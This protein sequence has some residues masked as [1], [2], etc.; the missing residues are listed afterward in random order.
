MGINLDHTRFAQACQAAALAEKA[1]GGIGT[2]GE[3]TLHRVLK[4][5]FE[6]DEELHEARIGGYVADIARPDG[7]IEI[8]TGSFGRLRGKLECFLPLGPVTVA[9]PVAAIK[10][11]R[12]IDM[13]T[14]ELSEP[15]KSPK[16]G[17]LHE[18]LPELG[19]IREYL[20]HPNFRLCVLLLELEELRYLNGW[21]NGG[22]RG[23]HRCDRLP[24]ALVDEQYFTTP[25]DYRRLLPAGLPCPFRSTDLRAKTR[26]GGF[27]NSLALNA[28]KAAGA[29]KIVGKKGNAFLYE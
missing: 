13:Q 6:P 12:W 23:S 20:L 18:V 9:Y 2:L 27:K 11:L 21:G 7:I 17:G 16:R 22:K 8:Q 15:R 26:W 4:R 24:K 28:L 25:A 5:Y 29:V 1:A 14:G 3:G 19:N 10:R